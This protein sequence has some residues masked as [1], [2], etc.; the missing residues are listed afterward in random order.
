MR[1]NIRAGL[2]RLWVVASVLFIIAVALVSYSGIRNKFHIANTDWDAI[3]ERFGGV[4]LL[5]VFC[6][7]ARGFIRR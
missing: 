3:A 1:M 6:D 5:P 2:F 7:L 4:S